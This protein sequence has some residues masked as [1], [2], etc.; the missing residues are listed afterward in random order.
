M[1]CISLVIL[2]IQC[3]CT[4]ISSLPLEENDADRS[5]RQTLDEFGFPAG[6]EMVEERPTNSCFVDIIKTI[7]ERTLDEET[8]EITF[9]EIRMPTRE[10][11]EG[12]AGTECNEL[13]DPFM[14]SNPCN[15]QTCPN[16]PEAQ[17]AVV[18]Q[19]GSRVPVFLNELGQIVD[20]GNEDESS[21]STQTDTNI[22]T[23][24]CQGF[25]DFDPCKDQTC[26][27]FPDAV[28]FQAGCDCQPIWLLV[29]GVQVNCT[30]GAHVDPL[31]SARSRRQAAAV[32]PS[33]CSS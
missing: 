29:T 17:C 14:A 16:D 15:N 28:C 11:C 30:S 3:C 7:V 32:I 21:S 31:E 26:S 23:L 1:K 18:N 27:P 13:V 20:C 8:G 9:V 5:A 33:S 19:C 25:C 4:L 24:S 2:C 22:V 12:Y 10:C 6:T